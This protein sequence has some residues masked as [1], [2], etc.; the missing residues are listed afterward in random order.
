MKIKTN[1]TLLGIVSCCVVSHT[2]VA[3]ETNAVVEL[4]TV[5]V[6]GKQ[7]SYFEKSRETALKT[8]T[9]DLDTPFSTSVINDTLLKDLKANT[10]E[11]SYDYITGFNRSGTNAN[12]FTIRGMSADLTNIQ[13]DG[14]PGLTSRFGSPVT[15]NIERVE[16]LK[17]PSSVLY[18]AMDPGG[19]VNIVTKKPEAEAKRTIDVGY[20]YFTEQSKGGYEASL[21]LT[22][23]LNNSG[24]VLYRFIAGGESKDSF[25]NHVD[26]DNIYLYP[27]LT[28]KPN[29][30]TQLDVQ[31]EYL[32][33]DR[34]ADNGLFV[35]NNDINTIAPIETYYQEPGDSDKDEGTAISAS[36]KHKF[37]DQLTAN[38]KLRS[39]KHTDERDLYESNAVSDDDGTLRR[40]NRHQYNE[41]DAHTLDAN[42][43]YKIDG[44]VEQNILVGLT[45][46]KEY[47]QF[48]RLAFDE[49]GAFININNPVYTGDILADDP[50]SFRHWNLYS[51]ALYLSDQI[52]V[53]EALSLT[54]G[55]RHDIQ[56]G[57]YHLSFLDSDTVQDEEADSSNTSFNAGAVY[58]VNDSLSVY[59]SYAESF[60][61]Q[62]I[63]TFDASG[64]QLAPEEGEQFEVGVKFSSANERLNL[65]LAL[66]DI[67]KANVAEESDVTGFDELIGTIE[68]RGLE[69]N[70]QYQIT[71]NLQLQT[72]YTYTDAEVTDT[73]NDDALGNV[74]GA[75]AKHAAFAWGRYNYP[76]S[77]LGGNV[78]ASAGVTYKGER[79]TDEETSKRVLLP[80]YTVI[81]VGLH[82]ERKN[83]KYALNIG[84]I[85]D[86]TYYI[87]GTNDSRIYAGDPLQLSLTASID[88]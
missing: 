44:A 68:S 37:N 23:P 85:T 24:T 17:G 40:R 4:D 56:K 32:K 86:E 10:L 59:G 22:G 79:Y 55:I 20:Q 54:A 39:V 83:A 66:F 49:R 12:A 75:V 81:D 64:D 29:D 30:N 15:A 8:E 47:R 43:N 70:L 5:F 11:D 6:N 65:N 34:K 36:L 38:V 61:P 35:L 60:N 26:S 3:A 45:V 18:G 52:Y 76:K 19:L 31:A 57:D 46:G 80:D 28:Y 16:V 41:R 71:D 82:Y 42:L 50:G 51:K 53:N 58:R 73:F 9:S 88:F 62:S 48:D 27:S 87:G 72:G 84:N 7:D 1:L 67:T 2:I 77:V 69:A 63:P 21:D 25:R 33:E 14:L 13:T 78:G 74:P